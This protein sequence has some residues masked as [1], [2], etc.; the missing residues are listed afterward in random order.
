MNDLS[1]VLVE[2]YQSIGKADIDLKGLTVIV[3]KGNLGKSAL[4]RAIQAC[5][6][7]ETGPG[8]IRQGQRATDVTLTFEGDCSVHWHK[9]DKTARYDV[10]IAG[11][12][13]PYTKLA[14]KVPA[15]LIDLFGVHAVEIDSTFSI[16]P[17][18]HNQFDSPFLLQESSARAA[19]TLG[20]MTKLEPILRSQMQAAS[21]LRKARQDVQ[22][23]E[24]EIAELEAR[25]AEL[26]DVSIMAALIL[27]AA[28]NLR[29]ADER[30]T[31][32]GQVEDTLYALGLAERA[33]EI[34]PPTPGRL[35]VVIETLDLLQNIVIGRGVYDRCLKSVKDCT[36]ALS[37]AVSQYE[38][39]TTALDA[40][41]AELG[42]CPFCGAGME[43][44]HG[45]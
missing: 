30:T 39:A 21:D 20:K 16:T 9:D 10:D 11:A 22:A 41:V 1:R 38:D 28:E 12:T 19:R 6:F 44:G 8:M 43:A 15:E 37:I 33:M 34:T 32:M 14:G 5:L 7:N 4:L 25:Q 27:K 31:R 26:P 3:G 45:C 2:N 29:Q 35:H 24:R 13:V 36:A 23:R 42:T 17:Q 18:V 40:Y